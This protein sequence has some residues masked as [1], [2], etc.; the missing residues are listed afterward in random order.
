MTPAIQYFDLIVIGAG[1]AGSAAA[2]TAAAQGLRTAL[3]DKARFPRDKLCGGGFTGRAARYFR[4][5]FERDLPPEFDSKTAVALYGFGE[6]LGVIADIPPVYLTMRFTLDDLLFR[7]ATEAG[8]QD[9]TGQRIVHMAPETGRVVLNDTE[10]RAPVVIGADGINS[11]TARALFGRPFDPEE[12]GFALECEAPPVDPDA[13]LRIDMGAAEWG[14]GWSFPKAESHTVGVGGVHSRNPDLKAIM[15]AYMTEFDIAPDMRIKGQYLP[16]G[17]ARKRPGRANVLLAGDAA[18]LV[19]PVTGE[20]IAYAMKSGQQAA[21]AARDAL[22]RHEPGAALMLYRHRLRP[23]TQAM[24]HANLVRLLIY[25][26]PL[27]R[28]FVRAARGSGHLRHDYMRLLGGEIEYSDLMRRL[29][30]RLPGYL[31]RA[32]GL[33]Q[34]VQSDT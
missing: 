12:V 28:G 33:K 2:R 32:S 30:R 34:T 3:V 14:Y 25:W 6:K 29:F 10:L 16:F 27:Q 18:W 4:E 9:F 17:R 1:P 20:G 22:A 11:P 19:D 26:G 5:I 23:I 7:L 21:L 24:R 8:A 13:I 31:L 15:R